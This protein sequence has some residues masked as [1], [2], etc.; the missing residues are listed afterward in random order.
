MAFI[1]YDAMRAQAYN[2]GELND[3]FQD[4]MSGYSLDCAC[5]FL[6]SCWFWPEK[7]VRE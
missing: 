7:A 5:A 4:L 2:S 1:M 6:Q 3:I